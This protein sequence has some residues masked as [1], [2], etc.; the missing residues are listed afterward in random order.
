[1]IAFTGMYATIWF[2]ALVVV[3]GISIVT[4]FVCNRV[5]IPDC[6]EVDESS[7][8]RRG[9][10]VYY[11]V[12]FFSQRVFMALAFSING[13]ILDYFGFVKENSE[14]IIKQIP[15]TLTGIKLVAGPIPT[16][17]LSIIVLAFY[18]NY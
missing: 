11:G 5:M 2:F 15:G 18:P 4:H 16:I 9:E 13:E 17:I 1:M 10:G 3:A 8:G 12:W 6:I 14:E 7:T